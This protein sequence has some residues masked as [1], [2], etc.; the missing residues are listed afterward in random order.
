L[1]AALGLLT[2][3]CSQESAPAPETA[4]RRGREE[5][6]A[7]APAALQPAPTDVRRQGPESGDGAGEVVRAYY[8]LIG[9]G[10]YA[11]AYRLREPAPGA[12]G[13]ADFTRSFELYAEYR[14]TVGAPSEPVASGGWLYVEVPVQPYG[15]M[16]DGAPLAS[17]GTL[18]LRRQEG[19]GE[20]RIFTKG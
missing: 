15:R 9:A 12:P 20:W 18:T 13:L 5:A 16:K 11:E 17:A 7:A 3:A 2:A 8:A 19:G 1:A 14:A 4:E 6:P 10:R